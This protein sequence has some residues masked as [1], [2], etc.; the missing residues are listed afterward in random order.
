MVT[1]AALAGCGGSLLPV[2][3]YAA[4]PTVETTDP[5]VRSRR[6]PLGT[7]TLLVVVIIGVGVLAFGGDS[8]DSG[9]T[10]P[11]LEGALGLPTQNVAP[12]FSLELLDG[13]TFR[14]TDHFTSDGRP[15]ILNL[16]ASWCGPCRAEMPAFD[17][18][19]K[20][21]PDVLF[22]GVA[23]EDDPDA[24]REFAAEIGV[25]YPLAIDEADRVGRRYPSPGLPATYFITADGSI[26]RTVFGQLDEAQLEELITGLLG[27]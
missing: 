16:W 12:D 25:S 10:V 5:G 27:I 1:G 9:V 23:V 3:D 19:S 21:T 17:A 22:L 20:V 4:E 13:S 2:D 15:V 6:W 18:I 26:A 14:L 8:S 24:A 11:D 7:L